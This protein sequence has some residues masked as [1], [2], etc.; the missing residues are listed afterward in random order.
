MVTENLRI[1]KYVNFQNIYISPLKSTCFLL[2]Q[3]SAYKLT[4]A[5]TDSIYSDQM[6]AY[7]NRIQELEASCQ[8]YEHKMLTLQQTRDEP[9]RGWV[10]AL[11]SSYF[12]KYFL[13][14]FRIG[15]NMIVLA[16]IIKRKSE[17][18][19]LPYHL[20]EF[21]IFFQNHRSTV[22]TIWHNKI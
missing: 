9:R 5:N 19:W 13:I 18:L 22:S 3:E 21:I 15:I 8:T 11:R 6:T 4:L 10:Y 14:S 7:N 16:F 1:Y 17:F 20:D 12:E 2:S